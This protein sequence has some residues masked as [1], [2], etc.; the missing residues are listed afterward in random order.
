MLEEGE[1]ARSTEHRAAMATQALISAAVEL[2][3]LSRTTEG[4]DALIE[5]LPRISE[6]ALA[7]NLAWT[8]VRKREKA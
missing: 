2:W 6:A 7:V 8:E 4:Q 1:F 3:A 5:E